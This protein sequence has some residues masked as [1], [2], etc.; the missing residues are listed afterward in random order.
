MM[1]GI[2]GGNELAGNVYDIRELGM[3]GGFQECI[4]LAPATRGE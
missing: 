1:I 2:A 3:E 4:A